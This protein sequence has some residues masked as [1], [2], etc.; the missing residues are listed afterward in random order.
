MAKQIFYIKIARLL[1]NCLLKIQRTVISYLPPQ[2]YRQKK[3]N[4]NIPGNI[5]QTT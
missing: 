5:E 3:N 2:E 4:E 1:E